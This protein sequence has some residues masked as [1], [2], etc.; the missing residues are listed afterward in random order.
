MGIA[1]KRE[2]KATYKDTDAMAV[3]S[4]GLAENEMIVENIK[5]SKMKEGSSL[6]SRGSSDINF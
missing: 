2:I 5:E 6:Y 4:E 1:K 3:V